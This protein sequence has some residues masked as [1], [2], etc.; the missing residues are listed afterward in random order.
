M[1]SRQ[2]SDGFNPLL[3]IFNTV[4]NALMQSAQRAAQS[5]GASIFGTQTRDIERNV[6]DDD[7]YDYD[8]VTDS[9]H[10][11]YTLCS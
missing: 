9:S 5:N 1:Q 11:N 4:S 10:G 6:D 7:A 8:N 2:L 3:Q